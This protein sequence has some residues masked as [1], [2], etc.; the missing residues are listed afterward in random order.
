ML[1]RRVALVETNGAGVEAAAAR[2]TGDGMRA[3]GVAADIVDPAAVKALTWDCVRETFGGMSIMRCSMIQI[4]Y[5]PLAEFY[6]RDGV[7]AVNMLKGALI[8]AQASSC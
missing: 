3:I 8:C 7:M 1:V 2:L 5:K 6:W 4:P